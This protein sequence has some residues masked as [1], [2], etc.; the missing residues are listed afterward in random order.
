MGDEIGT[1]K[2]CKCGVSAYLEIISSIYLCCEEMTQ[3]FENEI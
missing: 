2:I 1:L 3:E